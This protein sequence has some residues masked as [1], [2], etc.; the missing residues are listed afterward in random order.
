MPFAT[1]IFTIL[2]IFDLYLWFVVRQLHPKGS[3]K[4]KLA[5]AIIFGSTV[6]FIALFFTYQNNP[7]QNTPG[8]I[9]YFVFSLAVFFTKAIAILFFLLDDIRRFFQWISM[10]LFKPKNTSSE[11]LKIS[12]S[13]FLSWMGVGISSIF[14]GSIF[15]GMKN[16]YNYNVKKVKLSSDKIPAAF[17]GF[18]IVQIS[19]IHSGSFNEA[20]GPSKG[21][22]MI[23]DLNPDLILF[24]GDLVNG[25]SHEMDPF[26]DV[27]KQLN[28][29]Y[30]VYSVLGNHDYAI[31]LRKS[32]E[33]RKE[34]FAHMI[35]VHQ[36]LGWKL[37]RD[38]HVVIDKNGASITLIGVENWSKDNRFPTHGDLKKASEGLDP[39]QYQI[40]MSH[41][42]THWEGEV[43]K[44]YPDIDLTLSG[45]THGM[46]FGFEIPG[47]KWSPV[48]LIY[49]HWMGMYQKGKQQ[50]YVN[51]GFGFIGYH[52]RVGILPEITLFEIE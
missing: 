24:T 27:F 29:P 11:N 22:Q 17:K 19:D 2:V 33:E 26:I 8:K 18:K 52:G 14:A 42:P 3:A 37:L 15:L 49:K 9:F 51:T 44:L 47:F 31:Y 16:R 21:I 20:D 6:V 32:E 50:L 4:R 13:G 46:Q 23:L 10:K 30:G 40:L 43:L 34:D 25:S 35:D 28:A 1:T 38:E 36:Q 7:V 41:D 12:R 5:T 45:H 48:S 39:S